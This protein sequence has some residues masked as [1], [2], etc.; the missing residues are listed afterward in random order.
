MYNTYQIV[1]GDRVAKDKQDD[2]DTKDRGVGD[3]ARK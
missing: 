3:H 2:E 1:G